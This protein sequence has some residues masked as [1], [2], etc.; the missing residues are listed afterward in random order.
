[1]SK[2]NQDYMKYSKVPIMTK[3]FLINYRK[4]KNNKFRNVI[5]KIVCIINSCEIPLGT[6]IEGGLRMP[7]FNG[8]II[9]KD[10]I[11]GKNCTI[12]QQVTIG[13][14]ELKSQ[15]APIIGDNVYIGAGAK[16]LGNI[17]IGNNVRIGSNA[18]I[19]KDIPDNSTVYSKSEIVIRNNSHA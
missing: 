12:Y 3:V 5:N 1:M 7:H 8:I 2:L 9:N 6:K 14:N 16:I 19:V 17:T 4:N 10:S 13:S 11:I 18:V 15:G